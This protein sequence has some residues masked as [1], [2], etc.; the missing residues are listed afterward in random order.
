[1][2]AEPL[3]AHS[4]CRDPAYARRK[5]PAIGLGLIREGPE[6]SRLRIGDRIDHGCLKGI[7]DAFR[8][9]HAFDKMDAEATQ[10]YRANPVGMGER[11]E[12]GVARPI[13]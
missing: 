1:M 9:A 7:G 12:R 4:T 13:G 5:C 2:R 10:D 11:E 3:R 6:G 8:K